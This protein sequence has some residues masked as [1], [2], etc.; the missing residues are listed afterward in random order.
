MPEHG[1]KRFLVH[2]T[3][4]VLPALNWVLDSAMQSW[5]ADIVIFTLLLCGASGLPTVWAIVEVLFAGAAARWVLSLSLNT[6]FWCQCTPA[7]HYM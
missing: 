4:V 6:F 3:H 2:L 5:G 1:I 7:L